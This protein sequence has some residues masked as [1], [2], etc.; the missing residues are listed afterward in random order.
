MHRAL[1]RSCGW[2]PKSRLTPCFS[3]TKTTL[4]H[5][6]ATPPSRRAQSLQH[7]V[8]HA[9]DC[10]IF[11]REE[12]LTAAGTPF[13]VFTP[14]KNAWLR[15]LAP[16]YLQAYPVDAYADRLA[17]QSSVIPGLQDMGFVASNLQRTQTTHRHVGRRPAVRG[18]PQRIDRYQETADFPA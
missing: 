14:Y 15:A 18:F 9:K 13:S 2:P 3:T 7:A 17:A 16:F 8:H 1:T 6:R 4:R 10:V 5:W 11:E 12:V